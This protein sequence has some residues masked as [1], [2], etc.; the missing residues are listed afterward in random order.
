MQ[1]FHPTVLSSRQFDC[2]QSSYQLSL[3]SLE[4]I[5]FFLSAEPEAAL[6]S[7][8][9]RQSLPIVFPKAFPLERHS[10][11]P[12]FVKNEQFFANALCPITGNI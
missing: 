2:T 5:K 1:S 8:A 10:F 4:I 9:I 3:Q 7:T 11:Q 6:P 12:G